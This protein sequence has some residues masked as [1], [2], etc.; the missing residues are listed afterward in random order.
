MKFMEFMV[1]N[2]KVQ[3]TS[4]QTNFIMTINLWL[5]HAA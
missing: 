4:L 1:Y 3:V 5:I 2:N